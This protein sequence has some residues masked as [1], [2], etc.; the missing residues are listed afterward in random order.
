MFASDDLFYGITVNV[1]RMPPSFHVI[2]ISFGFPTAGKRNIH[3][4]G[5]PVDW[6]WICRNVP[7]VDTLYISLKTC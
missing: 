2:L 3:P 7:C 5:F 1:G 6:L 4:S